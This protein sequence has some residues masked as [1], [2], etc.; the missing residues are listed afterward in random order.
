MRILFT[1]MVMMRFLFGWSRDMGGDDMG[2][3]HVFKG[4][5]AHTKKEEHMR[6][7]QLITLGRDDE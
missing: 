3:R 1:C 2:R 5:P 7:I 4:T 6:R